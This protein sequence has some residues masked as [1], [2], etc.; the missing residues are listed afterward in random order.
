MK[1]EI[2][3]KTELVDNARGSITA[4]MNIKDNLFTCKM[5]EM[6]CLVG[7]RNRNLFGFVNVYRCGLPRNVGIIQQIYPSALI[8]RSATRERLKSH[9]D[10]LLLFFHLSRTKT[11]RAKEFVGMIHL[12]TPTTYRLLLGKRLRNCLVWLAFV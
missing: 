10:F 8:F 12:T 2:E 3:G 9:G 4:W 1:K 7:K 5:V 11:S 6:L